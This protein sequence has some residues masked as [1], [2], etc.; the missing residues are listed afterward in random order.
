[1]ST[2]PETPAA[3]ATE[4]PASTSTE[5]QLPTFDG[6]FDEERAKRKIAAVEADK[7]KL[8]E[9]LAA[10]EKAEQEAREAQMSEVER[11]QAA[12]AAAQ[13]EIA[14]RDKELADVRAAEQRRDILTRHK[15]DEDDDVKALLDGVP[16]DQIEA[17]VAALVKLRGPARE[18]AAEAIPGKPEPRLTPGHQAQQASG[19]PNIRQMAEDILAN[20]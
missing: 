6:P 11:V 17:K 18:S 19:A 4:A 2:N 12:L 15:I 3:P 20:R 1:M 7:A 10:Y 14:K 13:A 16:A 8:R 9:R 5:A